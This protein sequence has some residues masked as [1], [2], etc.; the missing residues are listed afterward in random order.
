MVNP[1]NS[2]SI[3]LVVTGSPTLRNHPAV[4]QLVDVL[5]SEC[6][7]ISL[8]QIGLIEER[9]ITHLVKNI[10][11]RQAAINA[12]TSLKSAS[13]FTDNRSDQLVIVCDRYQTGRD[14]TLLSES[15]VTETR[16]AGVPVVAMHIG[17]SDLSNAV[18]TTARLRYR[19]AGIRDSY[20]HHDVAL[21][22]KQCLSLLD[23]PLPPAS[24]LLSYPV[25]PQTPGN[26]VALNAEPLMHQLTNAAPEWEL[27]THSGD[28][29]K[30][31]ETAEITRS[32]RF[33]SFRSA[34]QYMHQVAPACDVANH[35]PRWENN[36]KTLR[37]WLTTWDA[38][39]QITQ[40]D[41]QLARYFDFVYSTF[42]YAET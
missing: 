1:D 14:T 11:T 2:A 6:P 41:I 42:G 26:T 30:S 28:T 17:I 16:N 15:M 12:V 31:P 35:H 10:Q 23:M 9:Q 18:A 29:P 39:Q 40:R 37:I 13:N 20:Q 24:K 38:K 34:I 4:Q 7:A 25:A 19:T 8:S 5:Q 21:L 33:R 36:W 27:H 32:L 3:V 22:A